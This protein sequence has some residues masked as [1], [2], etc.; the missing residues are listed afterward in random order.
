MVDEYIEKVGEKGWMVDGVGM[1]GGI[2]KGPGTKVHG[3]FQK[4]CGVPQAYF[5]RLRYSPVRVSI[6][7]LSPVST[8]AGTASS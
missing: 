7:I 2:E 3:P 5:T 1:I 4:L 6:S 8:K